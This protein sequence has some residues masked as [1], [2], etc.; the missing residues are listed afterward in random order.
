MKG[1]FFLNFACEEGKITRS[2]LVLRLPSNSLCY[3]EIDAK[4]AFAITM[5]SCFEIVDQQYIQELKEKS[6]NEKT[7]KSTEYWKNVFK[8]WANER[9][10]QPNLEHYQSDVLDRTLSEFYAEL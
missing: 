7:K 10:L 2:R 9:N 4:K 1:V 3:R 6:E 5:A 8:R